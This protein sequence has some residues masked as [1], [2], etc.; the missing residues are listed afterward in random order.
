MVD[1]RPS[2]TALATAY[3]RA[4]HQLLD[5]EPRLLEDPV[6]LPLLGP[7]APAHILA[8]TD[9]YRSPEARGLRAHV[10]L[11]SRF[12]E[13]RLEEALQRG[14]RQYVVLGAGFD[15]F[16][17]RQPSWARP[18][19][20]VE[21]DG[22]ATQQV[23]RQL[24]RDAALTEPA[25]L[26]FVDIDFERESL[27]DGLV[28][29]GVRTDVPTV[30][31]W[32]GVTMY[33]TQETVDAVL[34]CIATFPRGSEVVLTFAWPPGDPSVSPGGGTLADRSARAGEPWITFFMPQALEMRLRDLGFTGVEF[35]TPTAAQQR[36]FDS[37]PDDLPAPRLA[38]IVSAIR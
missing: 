30:F 3:L 27:A 16:A 7:L 31:A 14:V 18:L 2:R 36:Y 34:G 19:T 21:V 17:Y 9:R 24:L 11:R 15:T 8:A 22:P 6:A 26:R 1:T 4:A 28:R 29:H 37:R 33:L 23:K 32:L 35:L 5:A 20:I 13:D 12:A 38:T 10:V 25:N